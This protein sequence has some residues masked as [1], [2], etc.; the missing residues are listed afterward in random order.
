MAVKLNRYNKWKFHWS[1]F[2]D[3]K[4]LRSIKRALKRQFKSS[5]FEKNRID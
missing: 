5:Q 2:A 1:E 3:K 4:N